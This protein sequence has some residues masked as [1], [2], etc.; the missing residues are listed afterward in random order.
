MKK[1]VLGLALGL[2]VGAAAAGAV[3]TAKIDDVKKSREYRVG[4]A[5]IAVEKRDRDLKASL[6]KEFRALA[7]D[8]NAKFGENTIIL[9]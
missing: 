1:F 3:M 5:V 4:A 6:E 9:R 7:A 8:I 2:S